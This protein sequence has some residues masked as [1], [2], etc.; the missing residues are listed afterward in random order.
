MIVVGTFNRITFP[1]FLFIPG[2]Q[3]LFHFWKQY[4]HLLSLIQHISCQCL[5][6]L[7]DM[8]CRP[9]SFLALASFGALF[10]AVAIITDTAFFKHEEVSTLLHTL[11]HSPVI[12]PLNNLL[13]NTNSSNLALHGLHSR[14]H[15]FLINLPEL[16]GPAYVVMV[17]CLFFSSEK[18]RRLANNMRF[19]SAVS[20]TAILSIFPHQEARFLVPTVPLLL[21]CL[22]SLTSWPFVVSWVVFNAFMGCLM[23]VFHQGGVVPVQLA[24]PVVSSRL[25]P[26]LV[27]EKANAQVFWWKTYPPPIW[28]LGEDTPIHLDTR[29]LMG[30]SG[31]DMLREIDQVLPSCSS[32][33]SLE[34]NKGGEEIP[35]TTTNDKV[36]VL[37]VAPKSATFLDKYTSPHSSDVAIRISEQYSYKNHVNLDDVDFGDDGI[38]PTLNRVVG[39]RG[40][41][42]W[43][44][45]RVC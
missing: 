1:A 31:V 37:L 17:A 7:C 23:G 22:P 32:S 2:L 38:L 25:P 42:V 8:I 6:I 40:L 12:T 3:V 11:L 15:H 27:Q 34:E 45:E 39:R 19:Y 10:T 20:A 24:M 41:A 18:K 28:L 30:M 44:V 29:D 9:S 4:A 16:L 14:Y 35:H 43:A 33:S 13:Y 36:H 26:L 5:M 21:S